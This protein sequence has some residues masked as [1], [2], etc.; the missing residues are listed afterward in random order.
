MHPAAA[1]DTRGQGTADEKR[2]P[3]LSTGSQHVDSIVEMRKSLRRSM[4]MIDG[5]KDATLA[6]Q[7]RAI[8]EELGREM[9]RAELA[10]EEASLVTADSIGEAGSDVG[11]QRTGERKAMNKDRAGHKA[12]TH[13]LR[14][15]RGSKMARAA[16]GRPRNFREKTQIIAA[17]APMTSVREGPT[18]S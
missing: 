13:D 7:A 9:L 15:L 14:F 16:Q 5:S 8:D 2:A 12:I 4:S 18:S 6:T 3:P 11:A 10:A 1:D 17:R